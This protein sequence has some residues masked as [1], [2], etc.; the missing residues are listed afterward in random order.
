MFTILLK[1]MLK[2]TSPQAL[3]L[4]IFLQIGPA[5]SAALARM[6]SL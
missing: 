6:T 5:P 2:T 4:L 1:A 3:L